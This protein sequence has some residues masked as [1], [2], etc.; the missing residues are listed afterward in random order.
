MIQKVPS[1]LLNRSIFIPYFNLSDS[2]RMAYVNEDYFYKKFEING[3]ILRTMFGKIIVAPRGDNQK[4]DKL[5]TGLNPNSMITTKLA[6]D[7]KAIGVCKQ[8]Y[9]DFDY[10]SCEHDSDLKVYIVDQNK[11][12]CPKCFF[13]ESFKYVL[14]KNC[15]LIHELPF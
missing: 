4:L 6:S 2:D 1:E 5:L 3:K 12:C 15:Y 11:T 7:L 14:G 10:L 9:G 13:L 8:N